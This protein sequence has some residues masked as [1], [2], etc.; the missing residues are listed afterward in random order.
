MLHSV[1]MQYRLFLSL[2]FLVI[3]LAPAAFAE[4]DA[5]DEAPPAEETGS[6]ASEASEAAEATEEPVPNP[7]FETDPTPAAPPVAVAKP[8]APRP[9]AEMEGKCS[10]YALDLGKELALWKEPAFILKAGTLADSA[11]PL[12]TQKR[13]EVTLER[14][15]KVRLA[16][17]PE[18][19]TKRPKNT[20][21]GL[22]RF[23]VP[24]DGMY[25]VAAGQR[26]WLEVINAREKKRVAET[27]F[28]MQTKCPSI[29][30]VI[31]YDLKA[32]ENYWLQVTNSD[33]RRVSL[34][35]HP[36]P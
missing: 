17:R 12:E 19:E 31:V 23:R 27:S 25:R 34:L 21:A 24:K 5:T 36:A 9:M 13:T 26:L 3:L 32:N 14:E 7:T 15:D 22:L 4:G 10:N 20:Y 30:K 16:V 35:V 11:G 28:E 29:A 33:Y 1:F 6:P 18:K 8:A 2:A